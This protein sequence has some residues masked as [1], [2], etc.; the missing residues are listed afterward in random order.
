SESSPSQICRSRQFSEGQTNRDSRNHVLPPPSSASRTALLWLP[1]RHFHSR[2]S[3]AQ[4]VVPSL[5]NRSPTRV[6]RLASRLLVSKR[7]PTRQHTEHWREWICES[8]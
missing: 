1:Q 6:H 4:A 7:R 2:L 5:Q 8:W 3:P